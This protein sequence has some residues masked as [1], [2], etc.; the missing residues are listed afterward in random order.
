[1]FRSL[2]H[3]DHV[4]LFLCTM[5]H[6]VAQILGTSGGTVEH[7]TYP[8]CTERSLNPRLL[9]V[10]NSED[11]LYFAYD[12]VKWREISFIV[13]RR[14]NLCKTFLTR[15]LLRVPWTTRRSNQSIL[16][17]ISPGGS[18]EGLMLKLK[19]QYFGHLMWRS[20]SFEKT[21]MLG[22]IEGRWRRGRQRKRWLNGITDSMD[23]GLG[24]LWELLMD[25]RPGV[26]RFMG[27]QRAWHDWVTELK[28]TRK[29]IIRKLTFF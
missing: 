7:H 15:K 5:P 8:H 23:M 14:G 3:F 22:K 18:L 17:E 20:D 25:R 28:W 27:S 4:F 6:S 1:M 2:I 16:K 9:L 29:K 24:G 21:L 13:K 26:L 12:V 19:L 10:P 11:I